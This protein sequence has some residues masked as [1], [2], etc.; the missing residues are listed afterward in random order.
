MDVTVLGAGSPGPEIAQVCAVAGHEVRLYDDEA[1]A[2]MDAVDAV[3]GR[4]PSD[5]RDAVDRISATTGFDA[6]VSDAELVIETATA[7]VATLQETFADI[8][9]VADRET[10]VTASVTAVPVTA[11]A[12]GLRHPG[13]A[14]GLR[15]RDPLDSPLVEVTVAEQTTQA[16]ADRA[17][18]FVTGL[19]HTPVVVRD[20]PGGAGV[21]TALAL[22]AEA[23]R[24]VEAGVAGVAAVDDAMELGY[25]HAVGPLAQADRAGLEDRLATFEYLHAKLGARFAPPT[26]LEDLV[27]AGKTGRPA[28]EGFYVWENGEPV[29]PAVESPAIPHRNGAPDD[30]ARE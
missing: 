11:V 26:L 25:D 1:N 8:E 2:V 14:V 23:M 6:A 16:T 9:E 4:L 27:A 5:D 20:A 7:N 24:V 17:R 3:E 21:R 12:A 28:G 19:D 18:S 22:E 13:R 15:F 10:L 29:E 30:P